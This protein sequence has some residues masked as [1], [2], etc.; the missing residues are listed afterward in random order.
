MRIP[1]QPSLPYWILARQILHW[2]QWQDLAA[3]FGQS[4]QSFH[5]PL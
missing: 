2:Y 1:A 5:E 3:V 4:P